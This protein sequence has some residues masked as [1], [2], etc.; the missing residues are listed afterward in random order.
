MQAG[1]GLPFILR[2]ELPGTW[3]DSFR[4]ARREML[5][6]LG[7]AGRRVLEEWDAKKK[8]Q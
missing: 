6:K 5:A 4:P 2:R 8:E 1:F 3:P 7:E